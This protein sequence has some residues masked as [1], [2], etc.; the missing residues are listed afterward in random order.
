MEHSDKRKSEPL[1]I[2]QLLCNNIGY[3]NKMESIH[4]CGHYSH[5]AMRTTA[6]IRKRRDRKGR[7]FTQEAPAVVVVGRVLP[8]TIMVGMRRELG[9]LICPLLSQKSSSSA[10]GGREG[11]GGG[12]EGQFS[13]GLTFC[14]FCYLTDQLCGDIIHGSQVRLCPFCVSMYCTVEP[15]SKG[16]FG[17]KP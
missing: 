16:H 17:T 1:L 2:T 15:P 13:V 5:F 10:S 9:R 14:W 3:E 4:R 7:G 11:E 6:E 12:V 8:G